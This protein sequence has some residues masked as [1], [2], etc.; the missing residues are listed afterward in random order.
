MLSTSYY[1]Y[2]VLQTERYVESKFNKLLQE[3]VCSRER[4]QAW[5]I[6]LN[7]GLHV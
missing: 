7:T 6:T 3:P 1:L 4:D 2:E 5:L